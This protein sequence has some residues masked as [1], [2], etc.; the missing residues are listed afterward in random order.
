MA[1][2]IGIAGTQAAGQARLIDAMAAA[3]HVDP[4]WTRAIDR[5]DRAAFGWLGP[6]QP[7]IGREGLVVAVAD[8]AVYNPE[9]FGSIEISVAGIALSALRT[10]GLESALRRLNADFALALYDGRSDE[11]WLAV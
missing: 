8:G 5:G 2:I 4:Q 9:E 11:L 3:M 10:S 7:A 6:D 1:R